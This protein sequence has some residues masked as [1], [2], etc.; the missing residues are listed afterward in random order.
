MWDAALKLTK[1]Q[2]CILSDIDMHQFFERGMRGGIYMICHRY[3]QANNQ[4]IQNIEQYDPDKPSSYIIYLDANNLYGWAMS[5]ALSES[6]FRWLSEREIQQLDVSQ[7]ADDA[8]YG[9]VF[10]VDL[11]YSQELHE[12][13]SDYP[14]A[15]ERMQ[16]TDDMLS[17]WQL[18]T[19][20]DLGYK[21]AKV[22]KLASNV[23]DKYNYV[24]H[25]RNLKF[26]LA[27]GD[28]PSANI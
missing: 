17:E 16:I 22:E 15:P 23:K 9:Y 3:A 13:H 12:H 6:D 1:V 18:D 7:V 11:E 28:S 26:Y 5:H 21:P 20:A 27:A 4:L 19:K 14:L 24:I 10:E 25:Y 8:D 2:L